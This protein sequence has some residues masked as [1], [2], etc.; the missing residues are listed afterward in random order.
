MEKAAKASGSKQK[1]SGGRPKGVPNKGGPLIKRI[2]ANANKFTQGFIDRQ[3]KRAGRW[4]AQEPNEDIKNTLSQLH[5][6]FN[7]VREQM[8][9]DVMPL[10]KELSDSGYTPPKVATAAIDYA[11]NRQ[12]WI[13]PKLK[14]KYLEMDFTEEQLNNLFVVKV[15][16]GKVMVRVGDNNNWRIPIP[17]L[18]IAVREP[19]A[20]QA[21]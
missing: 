11:P 18:H 10:L 15:A 4:E 17:K 13:K 9:E 3:V 21:A 1:K 14:A 2:A 7:H 20:E 16:G 19:E 8:A 12:V 5:Q 6:A